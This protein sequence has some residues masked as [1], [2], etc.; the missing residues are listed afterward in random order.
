MPGD[1]RWNSARALAVICLSWDP[2]PNADAEDGAQVPDPEASDAKI[3]PRNPEIPEATVRNMYI[4][5][6]DIMKY[7]ETPGFIRSSRTLPCV[8]RGSRA[9]FGRPMRASS[10]CRRLTTVLQRLWSGTPSDS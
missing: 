1:K 10:D 9:T 7:G 3:I 2:T 6:A 5:K 4:R 8:E